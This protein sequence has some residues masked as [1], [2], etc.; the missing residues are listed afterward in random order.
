M[1]SD[2]SRQS[3]TLEHTHFSGKVTGFGKIDCR[4]SEFWPIGGSLHWNGPD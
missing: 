1:R 4:G 3:T 2:R